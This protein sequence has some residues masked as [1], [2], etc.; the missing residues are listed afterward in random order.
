MAKCQ[1]IHLS[2][3]RLKVGPETDHSYNSIISLVY[4]DPLK[5]GPPYQNA[6]DA[7]PCWYSEDQVN[8]V[9]I[10]TLDFTLYIS[11]TCNQSSVPTAFL[12]PLYSGL[13]STIADFSSYSRS[14]AYTTRL[15]REGI[16][17]SFSQA[18]TKAHALLS[19]DP[20][21]SPKTSGSTTIK[22]NIYSPS[23]GLSQGPQQLDPP[24]RQQS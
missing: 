11:S 9:L 8:R 17:L 5:T 3:M 24:F 13:G 7:R 20:W 4:L 22:F 1:Q 19:F 23:A 18:P 14:T 10:R 2:W 15:L 21:K 16:R 12:Y 6:S